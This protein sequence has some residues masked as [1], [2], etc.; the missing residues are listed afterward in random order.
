MIRV[1]LHHEGRE[2][3][4]SVGDIVVG[5][6]LDCRVRFN[7][8]AVSRR[9]LRLV[10]RADGAVAHNLSRTNG[11]LLNG[12]ALTASAALHSGDVLRIGFLH[13]R[14]ELTDDPRVM[15]P[16]LAPAP[17]GRELAPG[18]YDDDDELADEATRPGEA[19]SDEP[20]SPTVS[21]ARVLAD[22]TEHTCPRC[23]SRSPYALEACP[24]CGYAWPAGR[25]VSRTQEIAMVAV[26]TRA[27]PRYSIEIP[28]VYSSESLGFDALVRDVS[29]GGMFLA[30]DLLDPVGT[31]CEVTALP[32]GHAAVSFT[33]VVA[34]VVNADNGQ[35]R[36]PGL[37]VR[38]TGASE[39]GQAWLD[40]LLEGLERSAKMAVEPVEPVE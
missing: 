39:A 13:L 34:H 26:T 36:V 40:R 25:P 8:P 29:R 7:D 1:V 16:S 31:V 35:G 10:V 4:L 22:G 30:T 20:S 17:V 15:R 21:L 27:H 14:V 32:D 24:R 18:L 37:G 12:V 23:R 28:I 6:G 3:P 2:I 9:H 19:P 5:R 33:A 38:F 11:T